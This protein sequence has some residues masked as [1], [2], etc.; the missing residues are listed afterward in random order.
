MRCILPQLY[1]RV[2]RLCLYFKGKEYAKKITENTANHS[3]KE[4]RSDTQPQ[5]WQGH[6]G[7]Y[8]MCLVSLSIEKCRGIYVFEYSSDF[9]QIREYVYNKSKRIHQKLAQENH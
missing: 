3:S 5:S 8:K 2:K 1:Q 4:E 7:T 9:V 6:D